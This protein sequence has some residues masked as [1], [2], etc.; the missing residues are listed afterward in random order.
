MTLW[1]SIYGW[2]STVQ[3]NTVV[4]RDQNGPIPTRPFVAAKALAE[5]REGQAFIGKLQ[6]DGTLHIQQGTL[7]TVSVQVFGPSAFS[8]AQAIRN[9]VNLVTVQERNRKNGFVYVQTVGGPTDISEVVGTTWEERAYLDVQ[10][11]LNIDMLDD[12]GL[13]EFVDLVGDIES[14]KLRAL[15][16][17]SPMAIGEVVF[18]Q[19]QSYGYAPAGASTFGKSKFPKLGAS[20]EA[21][22]MMVRGS[23][24]FPAMKADGEA[25]Y[26]LKAHG[27]IAF[28]SL[29]V[30]AASGYELKAHGSASFGALK[31]HGSSSLSYNFFADVDFPLLTGV[32]YA[33]QRINSAGQVE[34]PSLE[35]EAS[36]SWGYGSSAQ[37]T[38][39]KLTAV[40]TS[41]IEF[42]TNASFVFGALTAV[43][44]SNVGIYSSGSANFPAMAAAGSSAISFDSSGIVSF[45]PLLAS[46]GV[47]IGQGASGSVTFPSMTVSGSAFWANQSYGSAT[48]PRLEA[49]GVALSGDMSYGSATFGR[50][51]AESAAIASGPAASLV[52]PYL[53]ASLS[54]YGYAIDFTDW[55]QCF[56]DTAGLV[57]VT[58]AGQKIRRVEDLG[59][60][61]AIFLA[62]SDSEAPVAAI[63]PQFGIRCALWNDVSQIMYWDNSSLGYY[64]GFLGTTFVSGRPQQ[65]SPARELGFHDVTRVVN[66]QSQTYLPLGF[67]AASPVG[68]FGAAQVNNG[69]YT[70]RSTGDADHVNFGKKSS[71]RGQIHKNA[72]A[73]SSFMRWH[74]NGNLLAEQPMTF[75][76]GTNR[77]FTRHSIGGRYLSNG[78][79]VASGYNG[80]MHRLFFS[81][82]AAWSAAEYD[83]VEM[84]IS[85]F[86]GQGTVLHVYQYGVYEEGV[87]L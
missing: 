51:T 5:D 82:K 17:N 13:I 65:V 29:L 86:T 78:S 62:P 37:V 74:R 60:W 4:K 7:V 11:R 61:G 10:F 80:Y 35:A 33:T 23:A 38:F 8:I 64:D 39:G 73:S 49:V 72:V 6:A 31:A 42:V 67:N 48:F 79:K 46:S 36:A 58:A 21:H 50:M 63:D 27:S 28:P 34:F 83:N 54:N 18:P 47:E 71:F 66:G 3:S 69:A 59:E 12:V 43:G 22:V 20:G 84:W 1:D 25:I 44:A 75:P 9:S 57:P 14:L 55:D 26:E 19:L 52:A 56:Q 68:L 40:G 81:N 41:G 15:I 24:L 45:P 87:Y 32:G 30:S 53:S 16:G 76:S 2:L 70:I 77:V 85:G